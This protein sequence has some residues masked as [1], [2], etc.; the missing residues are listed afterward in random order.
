MF[1][2]SSL[3]I[4]KAGISLS[5]LLYTSYTVTIADDAGLAQ[6]FDFR[7]RFA[8]RLQVVVETADNG[9]GWVNVSQALYTAEIAGTRN[10]VVMCHEMGCTL[11]ALP[12]AGYRFEGW[13]T[14]DGYTPVSYTHLDVY[15]RQRRILR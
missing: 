15:K 13:Y 12:A 7:R 8:N 2:F 9:K 10:H 4:L 6:S 3:S 11:V 1:E 5:C 14:T